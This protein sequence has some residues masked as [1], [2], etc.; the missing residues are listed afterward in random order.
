MV[1]LVSAP[2]GRGGAL[3]LK[4]LTHGAM[5]LFLEDGLDFDGLKLCLEVLQIVGR[6]VAAAAGVGHVWLDV[7][8]FV[9]GSAP[10]ALS[11]T[12]LLESRRIS[13]GVSRLGEVARKP[14]LPLSTA[15]GNTSVV[16]VSELVGAS[17]V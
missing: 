6:R 11:T 7:H 17:H 13:I 4:L 14:R 2:I 5:E 3:L 10:I 1:F 16:A 12:T 8:K 9:T 15:I